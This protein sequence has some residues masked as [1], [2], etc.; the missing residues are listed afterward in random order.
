MTSNISWTGC[1]ILLIPPFLHGSRNSK[2]P[3]R[4]EVEREEEELWLS[5]EMLSPPQPLAGQSLRK[6]LQEIIPHKKLFPHSVH[7]CSDPEVDLQSTWLWRA[8]KCFWKWKQFFF[9][10]FFPSKQKNRFFFFPAWCR[11]HKPGKKTP[12]NIQEEDMLKSPLSGQ[13]YNDQF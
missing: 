7:W 11:S 2:T 13:N 9:F 8:L 4:N 1:I 6:Q 10:F 3:G 12:K 5:A